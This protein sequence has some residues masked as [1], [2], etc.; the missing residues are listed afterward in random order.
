MFTVIKLIHDWL[1]DTKKYY[2]FHNDCE[3]TS[4]CRTNIVKALK[5]EMAIDEFELIF[6]HV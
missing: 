1:N 5:Y 2:V 3:C 4:N 6:Q